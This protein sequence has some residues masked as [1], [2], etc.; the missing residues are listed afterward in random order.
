MS[1]PESSYLPV[2][3]FVAETCV[4]TLCIMRTILVTRG[5][6]GLAACLGFFEVSIWL[7]AIGQVMSNLNRIDCALAFAGGFSLGNFLGVMLEQKLAL[8]HVV[9]QVTTQN[10]AAA[11]VTSLRSGSYG[12]TSVNA[13][14][15]RGPFQV[16]YTVVPRRELAKVLSLVQ[17]FDRQAFY[18][19]H[20][21]QT[22][23]A[24]VFPNLRSRPRPRVS[25]VL[26]QRLGM[27][28]VGESADADPETAQAMGASPKTHPDGATNCMR[29]A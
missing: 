1:L 6:K 10:D 8:G 9:V 15:A 20:Y 5:W 13:R 17:N 19:V 16:V 7:F 28:T 29:A 18:A 3:V 2:I 27:A 24:G 11:L 22:T 25:E 23:A 12:V 21:L 4:V 26:S 14:G